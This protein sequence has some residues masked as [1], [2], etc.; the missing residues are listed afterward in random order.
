[1]IKKEQGN[2]KSF[3]YMSQALYECVI[4]LSDISG[5]MIKLGWVCNINRIKILEDFKVY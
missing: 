2:K 5:G 1:M 3:N 4:L